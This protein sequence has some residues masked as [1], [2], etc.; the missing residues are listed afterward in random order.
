MFSLNF[1][2]KTTSNM[3]N[4][5]TI[6]FQDLVAPKGAVL[7]V[8]KYTRYFTI[9]NGDV[10]EL[11]YL[12]LRAIQRKQFIFDSEFCERHFFSKG[13]NPIA[14]RELTFRRRQRIR[15]QTEIL[16]PLIEPEIER[17]RLLDDAFVDLVIIMRFLDCL[18]CCKLRK[19]YILYASDN[20]LEETFL[21][22]LPT[23]RR[24]VSR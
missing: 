4:T 24:S 20:I 10:W 8:V 18:V 5:L 2:L 21:Y 22:I 17:V 12:S 14:L 6:D 9:R 19:W 1:R 23:C 15:E 3:F 13:R 16:E 7:W 11:C